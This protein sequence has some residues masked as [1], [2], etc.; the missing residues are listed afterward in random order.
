MTKIVRTAYRTYYPPFRHKGRE[1][2]IEYRVI[3]R[4]FDLYQSGQLQGKYR[5][6]DLALLTVLRFITGFDG[7]EVPPKYRPQLKTIEKAFHI[8]FQGLPD[9]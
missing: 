7:D 2:R 6:S 3:S 9:E 8:Q 5:H 1:W 4:T